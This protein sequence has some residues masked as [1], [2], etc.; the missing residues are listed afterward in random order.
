[1]AQALLPVPNADT[2]LRQAQIRVPVPLHQPL[3]AGKE[4]ARFVASDWRKGR[5][6]IQTANGKIQM[7]FHLPFEF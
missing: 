5:S 3:R 2:L 6:A 4:V 1:V 7:V